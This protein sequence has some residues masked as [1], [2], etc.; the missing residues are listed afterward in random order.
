MR[1]CCAKW[2]T[3]QRWIGLGPG[4]CHYRPVILCLDHKCKFSKRMGG[5]GDPVAPITVKKAMEMLRLLLNSKGV[6]TV[7]SKRKEGWAFY[8]RAW[9][10]VLETWP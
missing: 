5:W 2:P 4:L 9:L 8:N 10:C 3:G 6:A 7:A 1:L